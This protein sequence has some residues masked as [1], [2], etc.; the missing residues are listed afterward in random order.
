MSA[1]F[2]VLKAADGGRILVNL[3]AIACVTQSAA[4]K[5][6]TIIWMVGGEDFVV[7]ESIDSMIAIINQPIPPRLG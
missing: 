6:Q 7:N 3:T 1:I 2:A 4:P 5:E